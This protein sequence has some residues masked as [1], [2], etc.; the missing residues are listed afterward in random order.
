MTNREQFTKNLK[1][2]IVETEWTDSGI[3]GLAN[4]ALSCDEC[5]LLS[6]DCYAK[7]NCAENLLGWLQKHGDG[8][9]E[10]D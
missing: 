5:P 7:G 4:I 6:G 3:S 1:K 2:I 8:E 9:V 10:D